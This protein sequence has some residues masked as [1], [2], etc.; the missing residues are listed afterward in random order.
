MSLVCACARSRVAHG[1]SLML[2]AHR[3]NGEQTE[4]N[5]QKD[6][7]L[8][9]I[10]GATLGFLWFMMAVVSPAVSAQVRGRIAM[11]TRTDVPRDHPVESGAAAAADTAVPAQD[12]WTLIEENDL[13]LAAATPAEPDAEPDAAAASS[14][15]AAAP[16]AKAMPQPPPEIGAWI[17]TSGECMHTV[18]NCKG[19]KSASV[20]RWASFHQQR[21]AVHGVEQ[22]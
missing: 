5:E 14:A 13:E 4:E 6:W 11:A 8:M 20:T 18:R 2:M 10:V 21:A 15:A 12:D 17:S 22:A 7:H 16:A 3:A 9:F 19:L 1:V